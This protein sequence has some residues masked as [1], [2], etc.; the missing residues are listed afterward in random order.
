M[1][2]HDDAKQKTTDTALYADVSEL[3][4]AQK[5]ARRQRN[6][7]IAVCLAVFVVLFYAATVVKLGPQV[8]SRPM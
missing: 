2:S 4:E 8:L 5:K 1:T 3:T 6:I 7:A